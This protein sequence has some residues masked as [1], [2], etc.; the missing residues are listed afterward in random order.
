MGGTGDL[1]DYF[2]GDPAQPEHRFVRGT[3]IYPWPEISGDPA[4]PNRRIQSGQHK[5]DSLIREILVRYEARQKRFEL[6]E[7]LMS[8]T[9]EQN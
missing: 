9:E 6:S 4:S 3:P 2:L 8:D 7:I 5:P 1:S